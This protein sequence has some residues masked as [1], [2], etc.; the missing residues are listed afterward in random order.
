[1][2]ANPVGIDEFYMC[3]P[4][5]IV[6]DRIDRSVKLKQEVIGKFLHCYL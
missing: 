5:K 3:L 2:T 6:Q 1:M 4:V